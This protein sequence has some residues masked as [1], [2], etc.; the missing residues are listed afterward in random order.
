MKRVLINVEE[1]DLRIAILEDDQLTELYIE[2]LDDRTIL[3]NIYKGRVEGVVPGLKAAFVNIGLERNAFLHFDDVRMDLRYAPPGTPGAV[4]VVVPPPAEA[5]DELGDEPQDAQPPAQASAG[6]PM[7]PGDVDAEFRKR[8]RGRRGGRRRQGDQQAQMHQNRRPDAGGQQPQHAQGS[9]DGQGRRRKK[10]RRGRNRDRDRQTAPIQQPTYTPEP[11]TAP[12]VD[13]AAYGTRAATNPFDVYSPYSMTP[14]TNRRKARTQRYPAGPAGERDSQADFFGNVRQD[15]QTRAPRS[16]HD[17]D[18][19]NEDYDGPAPGNERFPEDAKARSI[20]RRGRSY[21]AARRKA[22]SD[23]SAAEES[24]PSRATKKAAAE[25]AEPKPKP[26]KSK[27]ETKTEEVAEK[28][29]RARKTADAAAEQPTTPKKRSARAAKSA[30]TEPAVEPAPAKKTRARK[31]VSQPAEAIANTE[32]PAV[33]ESLTPPAT[34]EIGAEPVTQAVEP[35]AT[36]K[37]KR[38]RASRKAEEPAPVAEPEQVSSGFAITDHDLL[39]PPQPPA[40]VQA[41]EPAQPEVESGAEMP[42]VVESPAVRAITHQDLP[43]A[44]PQ[45]E[46]QTEL[47]PPPESEVTAPP[48]PAPRPAPQPVRRAVLPVTEALKKG[49][50]IMVQVIKEE[51]GLKGARITTY[52]SLPGRYLVLLPFPEE[53]GGVSRKVENYEERK[54]LKRLLRD[55]RQDLGADKVGFIVRTAGVDRDE[56]EI[57]SDVEFL[58]QEWERVNK[59]YAEISA[60]GLAY[61]DSNILY[62]L[63]RDV[64]DESISEILID[65]A[66]EAE[67]LKEI[68]RSL[69]PQLVD[70]V[71]VYDEPENIF[72]KFQVERQIQKA[73]RRKVWLKSGGYLIIDEAEALTAI[74]VNTGKFVGKDDQE[75]MILKT[76]LEA[77]RAIARELKLRDIGGIIVIDFIDMKDPRNRETLLNEFRGYLRRD[78]SKTSVSG[79]SEFGLVEMT[80]KRVR[81]SLRKT[82]FMDCPYCQGAG[83]VLNESQ[84]WLHIKHDIVN[85]LETSQPRPSLHVVVNPRLRAFIEQ[86]YK[87]T[88]TRW[89]EKY[90]VEVT[91]GMSDLLHVENYAIERSEPTGA[92]SVPA[93]SNANAPV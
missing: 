60:P 5:E 75:K 30:E 68:L 39:A 35:P 92:E 14:G 19:E 16:I 28:P 67:N 23:E 73:G 51:I 27:A 40:T 4:E 11:W 3:N 2:S 64:F 7:T 69:I 59:R 12:P 10:R 31:A 29:K 38:R 71:K 18:Y 93:S 80:R 70:K 63:A 43:P 58:L 62:R 25:T 91:I 26:R 47:Q 33:A 42:P 85:I 24:K 17:V 81:Q 36:E 54:R 55:I 9:A 65:S 37:P 90:G 78:R 1:R 82:L 84:I 8:R 48:P 41:P 57:R 77:A 61:D 22:V 52:I 21:Y 20:R 72:H 45:P 49:D 50:E 56:S 79:I 88:I 46:P 86:N 44:E 34:L 32:A 89:Q 76:N 6:S 53:E 15:Q 13:R 83:V 87:D 66:E 74:D